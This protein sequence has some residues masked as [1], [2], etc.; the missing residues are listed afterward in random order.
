MV[1]EV[2]E[3]VAT[4]GECVTFE[5]VDGVQEAKPEIREEAASIIAEDSQHESLEAE[6]V[7]TIQEATA[8]ILAPPEACIID[9]SHLLDEDTGKE[10]PAVYIKIWWHHGY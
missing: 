4:I 7:T 6:V 1:A 10:A 3:L 2:E 9:N 8:N 5:G